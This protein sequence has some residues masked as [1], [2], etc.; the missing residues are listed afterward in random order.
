MI[1]I[2]ISLFQEGKLNEH[3]PIFLV[4]FKTLY[5]QNNEININRKNTF[6]VCTDKHDERSTIK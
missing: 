6:V 3:S 5:K 1:I 2:I 4:A